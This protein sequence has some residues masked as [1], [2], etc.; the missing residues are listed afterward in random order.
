MAGTLTHAYFALDTYNKLDDTLKKRLKEY[1]E[2]LKTYSQGPDILFF[3]INYKNFKKVKKIGN[4]V[5]KH[6]TRDFFMNMISYIKRNNLENNND[7]LTFLYG[8]IMHY[9]L[10][11]KV[12]PYVI[13][14]AGIFNKKKK[15]TYKYNSKHSDIE[16]YIDAYMINYHEN[17]KPN[18]F[19]IHKFCFN[20]KI[21]K[22]LSK[23]I[24]YSFEKTYGF[25]KLSNYFKQGLFNMKHSYHFLRYDPYG[26][27]NKLYKFF[28]KIH[29]RSIKDFYPI[30]YSYKLDKNN[31]YLNLQNNS[32]CHP[33]Y[34]NEIHTESFIDLYNEASNNAVYMINKVNEVLFNNKNI[35][36]LNNVFLNLSLT[37]GKE[38]NDKEK[39]KYFEF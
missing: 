35:D 37:S 30:T 2:N 17:I 16:S 15:N 22:D 24:D 18:K 38:C 4:Y 36:I 19:K 23:V 21:S 11:T 33:R 1:K 39:N 31:Y 25:K 6:N 8:Y 7:I 5:H 27:K 29:P 32:W 3:S 20:N 26:I 12:H 13:Y 34:K 28:D 9:A 10:D 14:K